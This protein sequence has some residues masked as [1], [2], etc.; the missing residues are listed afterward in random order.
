MKKL[1]VIILFFVLHISLKSNEAYLD[2]KI[3]VIDYFVPK[4]VIDSA[5]KWI[6]ITDIKK[7]GTNYK[8]VEWHKNFGMKPRV[9]W[10]AL[11]VGSMWIDNKLPK[12]LVNPSAN[13]TYNNFKKISKTKKVIWSDFPKNVTGIVVWKKRN[14]F[15]G[16]I[17]F[18]E[19]KG[20]G[21]YFITVEGNTGQGIDQSGTLGKGNTFVARK[22]RRMDL[23]L[24]GIGD[25]KLLR[26]FIY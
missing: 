14:G 15:T 7:S 12:K 22:M 21:R 13:G 6:G 4:S 10:C 18:L 20:I 16:H 25:D 26:G 8:I 11:F 24:G 23:P 1:F 9:P 3:E 19:R 17:G 2:K 5:N